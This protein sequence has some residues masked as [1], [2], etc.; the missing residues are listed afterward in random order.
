MGGLGSGRCSFG[1]AK[2]VTDSYCSIDIRRWQRD[3]LLTPNQSFNW[4]WS[5]NGE[6]VSS[7]WV[8]VESN[9]IILIYKYQT[10]GNSWK[11][12]SIAVMLDWSECNFGGERPWFLCP[13]PGCTRRVAVLH[14]NR[15]FACRHCHQLAYSSQKETAND[16]AA[17]RANKIRHR[18]GWEQGILNSKEWKKPKGMHWSTFMRLNREHDAFVSVTLAG[19]RDRLNW[20][21]SYTDY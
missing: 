19:M 2:N 7:I 20:I 1:N 12:Q 5:I 16:R 10:R 4:E 3:G 11:N 8:R 14:G 15:V 18:L 21:K 9:K 13:S 17:R 6:K